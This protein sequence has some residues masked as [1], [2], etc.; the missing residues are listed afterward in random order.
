MLDRP[1]LTDLDTRAEIKGSR[2]PLGVQP[3]WTRF[4]RH[5][6]GNLTTVSS[7]VRD[8]T[9]LLLGYWF[10]E[11]I[12]DRTGPG[13]ELSTF[14]KWEQLAA[15]A[16]V[17][18]N[19]DA[20]GLR[21]ILRVNANLGR[22]TRVTLS[23]SASSQILGNQ[24]IYGLW[25]LYTVP[26]R[27]SRLLQG[28]PPRLEPD[29]R[30]FV[31]THYL[32]LLTQ[33]SSHRLREVDNLLMRPTASIDLNGAERSL[34]QSVARA[35]GKKLSRDERQFYSRYLMNGGPEDRTGGLQGRLAEL[36]RDTL[37]DPRFSS[38]HTLVRELVKRA[39][40]RGGD[41]QPLAFRLSRIR[42]SESVLAPASR[43]FNYLLGLHGT[44]LPD[45]LQRIRQ[46]WG[47]DVASAEATE[48]ADLKDEIGAEDSQ[49]GTRWLT[50]A[51]ALSV[52]DYQKLVELL[53]QQNHAVMAQRGG[54]PWMEVRNGTLH[55]HFRSEQG[56]LPDRSELS[57]LWQH[58]YFITSLRSVVRQLESTEN[59]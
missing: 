41:W 32:P 9:T 1:F 16:R 30:N 3:I 11:R 15:Y 54:P 18:V 43:A 45:V 46:A 51:K 31:E 19:K 17:H 42:S 53:V 29:A 23:D 58:P 35:L 50:M 57:T 24:K 25:G 7:S 37:D 56:T 26:A 12:A 44:P 21:G 13:S 14:L 34:V 8:F 36:L 55:V 27:A 22:S 49:T 39:T 48:F 38:E 2:D 28:D 4:G 52:G 20:E 10:A 59:D 5:V 6:V 47:S 40:G 33:G